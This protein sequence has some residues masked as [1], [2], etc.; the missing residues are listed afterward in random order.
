[1]LRALISSTYPPELHVARFAKSSRRL[2][3]RDKNHPKNT[4]TPGTAVPGASYLGDLTGR[5]NAVLRLGSRWT[6]QLAPVVLT[7]RLYW[8]PASGYSPFAA[9]PAA[10]FA[11]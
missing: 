1:M 2:S 8:W 9:F 6:V 7:S 5:L 3:G 4:K 11:F 10:P